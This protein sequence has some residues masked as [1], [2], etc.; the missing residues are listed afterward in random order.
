MLKKMSLFEIKSLLTVEQPIN[1][2][3]S[4]ITYHQ[5]ISPEK[6]KFI[7]TKILLQNTV[8]E[9]FPLKMDDEHKVLILIDDDRIAYCNVRNL[10]ALE[11]LNTHAAMDLLT[12]G[13]YFEVSSEDVPTQ[14]QLNRL[15]QQIKEKLLE[16]TMAKV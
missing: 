10:V 6:S 3:Q 16:N 14:S 5:E 2:L 1:R 11:I 15:F 7:K 13:A 8:L 4:I 12:G 9:G